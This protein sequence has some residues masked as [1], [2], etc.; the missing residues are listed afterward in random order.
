M[1][2]TPYNIQDKN[3]YNNY[4]GL[5][6]SYQYKKTRIIWLNSAFASSVVNSGTTYY[7]L[8]WDVPCFE[9]YNQTKLSVVS[10]T[11][12]ESNAKP[13]IIKI[14]DIKFDNNS[15]YSSDKDGNPIIFIAH[16]GVS[17][18]LNNNKFSLTLLPQNISNISL[19]LNNSFTQRNQGF[20]ISGANLAGSFIIGLLFEDD[21]LMIDN[22]VSEYY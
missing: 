12:N 21:E 7:E 10:F 18:M 14:K 19:T 2:Q 16:T 9:L 20:T 17:G 8:S 5:K 13:I 11:S 1:N 15:T 4:L 3:T 22:A 6:P